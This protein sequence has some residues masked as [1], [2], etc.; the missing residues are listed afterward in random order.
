ME[1]LMS[2]ARGASSVAPL[3]SEGHLWTEPIAPLSLFMT[4]NE[5]LFY[6]LLGWDYLYSNQ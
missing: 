1:V 5:T 6:L 2:G 4:E 3:S